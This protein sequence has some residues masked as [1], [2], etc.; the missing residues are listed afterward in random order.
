MYRDVRAKCPSFFR[1]SC[2]VF[3]GSSF[4][5]Y[6]FQITNYACNRM[7]K[8]KYKVPIENCIFYEKYE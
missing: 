2:S 1:Y 7:L 6:I 3:L 5:H 4:M 8:R